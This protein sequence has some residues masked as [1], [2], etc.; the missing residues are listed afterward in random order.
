MQR[1]Q[2]R[3]GRDEIDFRARAP[4]HIHNVFH[5]ALS[6]PGKLFLESSPSRAGLYTV[7]DIEFR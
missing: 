7:N 3:I 1:Q 5:D 2:S 6:P 4:R